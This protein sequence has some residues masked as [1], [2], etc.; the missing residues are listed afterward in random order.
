MSKHMR[1]IVS[2]LFIVIILLAVAITRFYSDTSKSAS[3]GSAQTDIER[4]VATDLSGNQIFEDSNGL[5]GVVDDSDRV[6]VPAEWADLSFAGE[7]RCIAAKRISGSL[8][9]GAVDFEGNIVVPFIYR[10]IELCESGST[11][12]YIA[13]SLS[14]ESVVVYDEKFSPLFRKV[15]KSCYIS[16]TSLKLVSDAGNYTYNT[17]NTGFVFSRAVISGDA[18]GCRFELNV[19][20]KTLLENLDP[21]MLEYMVSAVSHYL[22]FAYTG[23]GNYISDIRT[24]GRPVLTKLFPDEPRILSK[25]LCGIKEISLAIA[26]PDDDKTP[27]YSI[28]VS[29]DTE[30]AYKKE[31]PEESDSMRENYMAIIEFSGSSENDLTVVS[32]SFVLSE[33]DY[34]KPTAPAEPDYFVQEDDNGYQEDIYNNNYAEDYILH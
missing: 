11:K 3:G 21:A 20:N 8:M 19:N 16:D 5:Y 26:A 25:K 30:L 15:W 1:L 17:D 4:I 28:A 31:N 9:K 23:D 33:P 22:E 6:I 29:A 12:V 14:D 2:L 7:G 24:G 32:G 13:Q 34:P 10:N 27:H 18:L